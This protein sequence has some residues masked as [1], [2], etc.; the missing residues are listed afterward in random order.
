MAGLIREQSFD[1]SNIIFLDWQHEQ[2]GNELEES[3]SFK[4]NLIQAAV[5]ER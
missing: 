2:A 1:E 3:G 5:Y 4:V